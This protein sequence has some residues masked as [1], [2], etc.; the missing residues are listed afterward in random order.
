[1]AEHKN[2]LEQTCTGRFSCAFK[3]TSTYVLELPA[4]D[5]NG[6]AGKCR[7]VY[8]TCKT[9][10]GGTRNWEIRLDWILLILIHRRAVS[11]SKFT[12]LQLRSFQVALSG[13]CISSVITSN[14]M[15]M[16]F[17]NMTYC[18]TETMFRFTVLVLS[19]YFGMV[20]RYISYLCMCP[21]ASTR[22]CGKSIWKESLPT[23]GFRPAVEL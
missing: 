2:F 10:F 16:L 21:S 13:A 5:R 18:R 3:W 7:W 11:S 20:I 23:W 12:H 6:N 19:L 15:M 1:M 22:W 14:P 8:S 17:P 9:V 4:Q